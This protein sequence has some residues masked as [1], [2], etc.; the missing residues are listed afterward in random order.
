MR[1]SDILFRSLVGMIKFKNVINSKIKKA[2]DSIPIY[3]AK[4]PWHIEVQ[5]PILCQF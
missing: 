4:V 2:I 3:Y 1:F 5:N